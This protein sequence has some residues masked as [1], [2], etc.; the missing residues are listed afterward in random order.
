MWVNIYAWQ[1]EEIRETPTALGCG[2]CKSIVK[3]SL[4]A[5]LLPVGANLLPVG[6]VRL[7][8]DRLAVGVDAASPAGRQGR[9]LGSPRPGD[10]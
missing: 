2:I 6:D 7:P 3:S 1:R 9:V 10:T 5:D 8:A 4:V